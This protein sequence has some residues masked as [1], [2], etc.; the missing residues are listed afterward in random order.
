MD[1]YRYGV[2]VKEIDDINKN[3]D[4]TR[5]RLLDFFEGRLSLDDIDS[6]DVE[7]MNNFIAE[8]ENILKQKD[9]AAKELQ[10]S[11]ERKRNNAK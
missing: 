11:E 5:L 8:K 3:I 1:R 10:E 4:V 7:T 9:N 2:T 6:L